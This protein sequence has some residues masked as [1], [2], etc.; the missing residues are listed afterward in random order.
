MRLR[1]YFDIMVIQNKRKFTIDYEVIT[2]DTFHCHIVLCL[3]SFTSDAASTNQITVVPAVLGSSVT[4]QCHIRE[5]QGLLW[6]HVMMHGNQK[7]IALRGNIKLPIANSLNNT[8]F[9]IQVNSNSQ[10]LIIQS[11]TL[12]DDGTYRCYDVNAIQ[13]RE[14]FKVNILGPSLNITSLASAN[15]DT[16]YSNGTGLRTSQVVLRV[17]RSMYKATVL[18]KTE[19]TYFFVVQNNVS[20]NVNL[21]PGVPIFRGFN[22]IF[23]DGQTKTI[24]CESTGSRPAA[25]ITWYMDGRKQN[26]PNTH[27]YQN[28]DGTSFVT[29]SISKRF[30]KSM[31]G[32]NLT[33]KAM[34]VVL[35]RQNRLPVETTVIL[36]AAYMPV[37]HASNGTLD[38]YE[39]NQAILQCYIDARPMSS[40][41]QVFW[42]KNGQMVVKDQ[43][44]NTNYSIK[45]GQFDLHIREV[46]RDDI[47]QYQC[48]ASNRLG[49]A[50]SSPP[51]HLNVFYRPVC[52]T[53]SIEKLAASIGQTVTLTCRVSANP[54][55]NVTITWRYKTRNTIIKDQQPSY[56][57]PYVAKTA[58]N[59]IQIKL[60]VKPGPPD[61]PKSCNITLEGKDELDIKCMPGFSGG[62]DQY[63]IL[64]R[65]QG[66]TFISVKN[67]N[68]EPTFNVSDLVPGQNYT[69]RVCAASVTYTGTVSCSYS[70]SI[71]TPNGNSEIMNETVAAASPQ[72]NTLY[73]VGGTLGFLFLLLLTAIIVL[74]IVKRRQQ[75]GKD[76]ESPRNADYTVEPV[77]AQHNTIACVELP[78]AQGITSVVDCMVGNNL[79]S[80]SHVI[81]PQ[82]DNKSSNSDVEPKFVHFNYNITLH[83]RPRDNSHFHLAHETDEKHENILPAKL[84][85]EHSHK[86]EESHH[87]HSHKADNYNETDH[88]DGQV[89]A[90]HSLT[91]KSMATTNHDKPVKSKDHGYMNTNYHRGDEIDLEDIY[92]VSTKHK[93]YAEQDQCNNAFKHEQI[94]CLDDS[95]R[96]K[97]MLTLSSASSRNDICY[98]E[99]DITKALDRSGN[100]DLSTVTKSLRRSSSLCRLDSESE[101]RKEEKDQISNRL[102]YYDKDKRLS[103]TDAYV[104]L[105]PRTTEQSKSE[106]LSD[107][108]FVRTRRST[109]KIDTDE[110]GEDKNLNRRR[111]YSRAILDDERDSKN[112]GQTE[113]EVLAQSGLE[114]EE[115]SSD[116]STNEG[117][118]NPIYDEI[119]EYQNKSERLTENET[120][121]QNK[122]FKPSSGDTRNTFVSKADF[123]FE[124]NNIN[125]NYNPKDEKLL[126]NKQLNG[127]IDNDESASQDVV[128]YF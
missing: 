37:I 6:D 61:I 120:D 43:R 57:D 98:S 93:S 26:N 18:C 83:G 75:V 108:P 70:L 30:D 33:C 14:S 3:L 121:H 89:T 94:T 62:G 72:D 119:K 34:N 86:H 35:Q 79:Y 115:V 28:P 85:D 59:S 65:I 124:K 78:T 41:N 80:S 114:W 128:A 105:F 88:F 4:L 7:I 11:L 90:L 13:K 5:A 12:Q 32:V 122:F 47:G 91:L 17:D 118:N 54:A 103:G 82:I 109:Y 69:Y 50:R 8:K 40:E 106:I 52:M 44:I 116:I 81:P 23:D 107:E 25:N 21:F 20:L 48:Q 19:I 38:V 104:F 123:N 111:S 76:S 9:F 125:N 45:N 2:E 99:S 64:Q 51:L 71:Q 53:S 95:I 96:S 15:S 39:H 31:D 126:K 127:I 97:S 77:E 24:T 101:N 42:L 46:K 63:F 117:Y 67:N 68:L 55:T 36:R 84:E 60:Q 87:S 1:L 66:L 113:D 92:A 110:N 29:S 22:G 74:C 10:S 49:I 58:T 100:H 73:I 27:T 112:V 56:T 102:L 16:T